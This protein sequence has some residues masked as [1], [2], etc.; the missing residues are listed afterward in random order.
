MKNTKARK[1]KRAAAIAW[2]DLL[3]GTF[4]TVTWVVFVVAKE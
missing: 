2:T 3:G 1:R 4:M